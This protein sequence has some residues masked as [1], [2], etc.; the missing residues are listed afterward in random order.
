[1]MRRFENEIRKSDRHADH[2]RNAMTT[3]SSTQALKEPVKLCAARSSWRKQ[4]AV[5]PTD[6]LVSIQLE[7]QEFLLMK[8]GE[9]LKAHHK[10]EKTCNLQLEE[11]REHLAQIFKTRARR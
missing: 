1:M 2:A 9:E 8:T 4:R 6:D 7:E 3:Q 11:H 10:E 5:K